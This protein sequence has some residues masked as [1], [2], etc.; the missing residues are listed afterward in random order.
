M[1]F[2]RQL[3]GFWLISKEIRFR[4]FGH[5]ERME[6]G[7]RSTKMRAEV[8]NGQEIVKTNCFVGW[9]FSCQVY[10]NEIYH[11]VWGFS[12]C[13][14]PSFDRL[15]HPLI[16]EQ[17]LKALHVGVFI[18]FIQSV[19]SLLSSYKVFVDYLCVT[20]LLAGHP[21]SVA[22]DLRFCNFDLYFIAASVFSQNKLTRY[23]KPAKVQSLVQLCLSS[24][25]FYCIL[26]SC[27][28]ISSLYGTSPLV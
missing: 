12:L 4:R 10:W 1:R 24:N 18:I 11:A 20:A 14:V 28:N 19:N 22:T 3:K 26:L 21:S 17:L 9:G 8:V 13:K 6:E 15:L 2:L 5:V 16:L 23:S 27:A 25:S 7:K